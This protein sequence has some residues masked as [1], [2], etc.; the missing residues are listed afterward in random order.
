[1]AWKKNLYASLIY[2]WTHLGIRPAYQWNPPGGKPSQFQCADGAHTTTPTA[3]CRHLNGP[4][5][6]CNSITR[7]HFRRKSNV[8]RPTWQCVRI[9]RTNRVADP[10][11]LRLT[12]RWKAAGGDRGPLTRPTIGALFGNFVRKLIHILRHFP[13]HL[14]GFVTKEV[15]CAPARPAPVGQ[16]ARAWGARAPCARHASVYSAGLRRKWRHW[17]AAGPIE[18]KVARSDLVSFCAL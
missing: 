9:I 18:S 16:P 10:F 4:T 2:K 15:D 1:M 3:I 12:R 17:A 7:H 13:V 6:K 14:T 11:E 5:D 8:V